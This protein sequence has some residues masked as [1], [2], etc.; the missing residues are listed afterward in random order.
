MATVVVPDIEEI[1]YKKGD[2]APY[3]VLVE[4]IEDK[5]GRKNSI[6]I[7]LSGKSL[8]RSIEAIVKGGP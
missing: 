6:N 1:F 5:V 7:N 4:T 2:V 3:R 8:N